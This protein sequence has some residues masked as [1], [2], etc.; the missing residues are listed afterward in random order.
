MRYPFVLPFILHIQRKVDFG[1]TLHAFPLSE[2]IIIQPGRNCNPFFKV[3][4]IFLLLLCSQTAKNRMIKPFLPGKKGDNFLKDYNTV[5]S[6]EFSSSLQMGKKHPRRGLGVKLRII[7]ITKILMINYSLGYKKSPRAPPGTRGDR[8]ILLF[9][10]LV[11]NCLRDYA[12]GGSS[13]IP[14]ANRAA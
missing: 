4:V 2:V 13:A 10:K 1:E 7:A 12:S 14:A 6:C 3:F 8:R 9:A 5:T 11:R